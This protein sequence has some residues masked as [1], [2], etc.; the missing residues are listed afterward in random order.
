MIGYNLEF[1]KLDYHTFSSNQTI[2]NHLRFLKKSNP[3]Y[4]LFRALI[5][6]DVFVVPSN[7]LRKQYERSKNYR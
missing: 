6:M 1:K 2:L 3:I 4:Q 5:E 7:F